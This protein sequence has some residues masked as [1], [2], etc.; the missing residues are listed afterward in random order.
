M[1]IIRTLAALAG[2]AALALA[3]AAFA[4]AW[5]AKTIKIIVPYPPGGTSDILA[6][7]LGPRIT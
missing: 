1:R 6:R 5:P 4:Q 3:G 7:S 2:T